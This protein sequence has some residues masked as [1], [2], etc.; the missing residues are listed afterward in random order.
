[1]Q[2]PEHSAGSFWDFCVPQSMNVS[3]ILAAGR[4]RLKLMGQ[5]GIHEDESRRIRPITAAAASMAS[6]A[7]RVQCSGGQPAILVSEGTPERGA[8]PCDGGIRHPSQVLERS[9]RTG[10]SRRDMPTQDSCLRLLESVPLFTGLPEEALNFLA[11]HSIRMQLEP[12]EI[13]FIESEACEGL[14]I[15]ESGLLKMYKISHDGREQ[16]LA[17]Y[18]PG[19]TLSE[20]PMIDGGM[21]P[22]CSAA[23]A[24]ST[25]LFI[26][27]ATVRSLCG[28]HAACARE[29]L[30]IVAGRLRSA[31]GMIEELSFST[32]RSRLAAYLLRA[33]NPDKTKLNTACVHLPAS[34]EIAAQIGTV[35]ELVSRNLSRLQAEGVIRI[36]RR[37]VHIPDVRLLASEVGRASGYLGQQARDLNSRSIA[38][39]QVSHDKRINQ[40]RAVCK[41]GVRS[42]PKRRTGRIA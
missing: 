4:P 17:T 41:P 25:V 34:Y 2:G 42:V 32:V 19:C 33:A 18:G 28:V 29:M 23:V 27:E 16:M 24:P 38:E 11:R 20:L 21:Y 37:T 13:L 10:C 1:M 35:R 39:G 36:N 9:G 15:V 3:L 26:P 12:D 22:F 31:L 8:Q 5:V 7:P 30:R 6:A 40:V 14:Y